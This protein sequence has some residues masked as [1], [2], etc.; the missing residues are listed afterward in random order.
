MH[1]QPIGIRNRARVFARLRSEVEWTRALSAPA[2]LRELSAIAQPGPLGLPSGAAQL[3]ADSLSEVG[4]GLGAYH[5][6]AESDVWTRAHRL[7]HVVEALRTA[8]ALI[9]DENAFNGPLPAV[10]ALIRDL[11][12]E[13]VPRERYLTA[14]VEAYSM[15]SG[16]LATIPRVP[17]APTPPPLREDDLL[18]P[19][20]TAAELLAAIHLDHRASG[21]VPLLRELFKEWSREADMEATPFW[22]WLETR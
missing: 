17:P 8:L 4:Q 14:V 9:D 10:G 15:E 2:P 11:L 13:V 5:A 22:I 21:V 3:L 12:S 7:S 6:E 16:A 19:G 20:I 18:P 1:T